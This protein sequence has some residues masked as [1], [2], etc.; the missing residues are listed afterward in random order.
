PL[1]GG[2]QTS[3]RVLSVPLLGG[4]GGGS[5]HGEGGPR[6]DSHR[7]SH[8]EYVH[9]DGSAPKCSARAT[10]WS[11]ALDLFTVSWNSASGSE[12]LTHPPPTWTKALP[13][14]MSA[15]RMVMQQ[16]RLPLN[17]K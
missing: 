15:V 9:P 10:A 11:I 13:C 7:A 5:V 8:I 4:V 6:L 2:E 17:E 12:S 16:S 1:P 14:L 3:V